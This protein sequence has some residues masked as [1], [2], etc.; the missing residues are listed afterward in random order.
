MSTSQT[1]IYDAWVKEALDVD[2]SRYARQS[3]GLPS[4]KASSGPDLMLEVTS[5]Q[6]TLE[7]QLAFYH[8]TKTGAQSTADLTGNVD[9]PGPK[10]DKAA[11]EAHKDAAAAIASIKGRDPAKAAKLISA[12]KDRVKEIS[13]LAT[14]YATAVDKANAAGAAKM[15]ADGQ[16]QDDSSAEREAEINTPWGKLRILALQAKDVAP[17]VLRLSALPESDKLY[18]AKYQAALKEQQD[19]V[20]PMATY[21]AAPAKMEDEIKQ[22]ASE[23]AAQEA[24]VANV[25]KAVASLKDLFNDN[26]LSQIENA[27][28]QWQAAQ[29]EL[30]SADLKDQAA[31]LACTSRRARET[32]G[33]RVRPV[34]SGHRAA[35]EPRRRRCQRR[36]RGFHRRDQIL[37]EERLRGEGRKSRE[38]SGRIASRQR[39]GRPGTSEEGDR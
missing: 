31:E 8:T 2:P 13:G 28:I 20:K 24:D 14:N 7:Q 22:A 35:C 15:T 25:G 3:S 21:L 38:T 9:D 10:I 33:F 26:L 5:A 11:A 37:L 34:Q 18:L 30:D 4:G 1:A 39:D 29:K 27:K 23:E 6:D 36:C 32:V 16:S 19:A 12:I 17:F